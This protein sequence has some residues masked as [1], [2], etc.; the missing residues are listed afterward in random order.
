MWQGAPAGWRALWISFIRYRR[1]DSAGP[2]YWRWGAE[3]DL[4]GHC[5]IVN[6]RVGFIQL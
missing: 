2:I 1:C 3:G 5:V 4:G 6:R